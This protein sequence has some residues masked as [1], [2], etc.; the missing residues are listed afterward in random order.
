MRISIGCDH[1][2]F[3]EKEAILERL[4]QE[5]HH[6]LDLGTF[7]ADPVDYLD[8]TQAVAN[9]VRSGFVDVGILICESGVGPSIAANKLKGIRVAFC[10]DLLTARQSREGADANLLCLD[11]GLADLNAAIEI[12]CEWL[13]AKFSGAERDVR[14]LS[15]VIQLEEGLPVNVERVTRQPHLSKPR[16]VAKAPPRPPQAHAAVKGF[17]PRLPAH[18]FKCHVRAIVPFTCF[19]IPS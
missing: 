2:G 15:R 7:S 8:L 17:K 4:K 16:K 6:I 5:D 11:A 9:A 10:H 1:T 13:G 18:K 12:S 14:R 19:P 3:P